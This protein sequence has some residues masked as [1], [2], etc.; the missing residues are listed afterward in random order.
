MTVRI[1]P[2]K[3]VALPDKS[4]LW[5]VSPNF[6]KELQICRYKKS[7]DCCRENIHAVICVFYFSL[8]KNIY[9]RLMGWLCPVHNLKFCVVPLKLGMN[10][11]KGFCLFF[12]CYWYRM[13][14][15]AFNLQF[16]FALRTITKHVLH[17]PKVKF[18]GKKMRKNCFDLWV[19]V[20]ILAD[21]CNA[22]VTRII[23]RTCCR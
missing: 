16:G 19:W 14:K 13:I 6:P 20:N 11:K 2:I 21:T 23:I 9:R 12:V 7:Y 1:S 8:F 10:N 4:G 3:S 18:P 22:N 15:D 5:H 17:M